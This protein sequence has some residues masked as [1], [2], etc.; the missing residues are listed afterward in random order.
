MPA[1][2]VRRI[3]HQADAIR[4]GGIDRQRDGERWAMRNGAERFD[5][6]RVIRRSPWRDESV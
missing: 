6:A 1:R 4:G 3:N 2:R 5:T